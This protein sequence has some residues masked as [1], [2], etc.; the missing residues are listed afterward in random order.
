[1]RLPELQNYFKIKNAQIFPFNTSGGSVNRHFIVALRQK[2]FILRNIRTSVSLHR[3][4]QIHEMVLF[5]EKNELPLAPPILTVDGYHTIYFENEAWQLMPYLS[6]TPYSFKLNEMKKSAQLL[7]K[8]HTASLIN[9]IDKN[10]ISKKLIEIESELPELEKWSFSLALL[11]KKQ[12]S[13]LKQFNSVPLPFT[14]THG[15]FHGLNLLFEEGEINAVLDFDNVD[16]RPRL[17]DVAH[18]VLMFCR[19]GRGSYEIRPIWVQKFL[20]QYG[21]LLTHDEL[22]LLPAMMFLSKIPSK[23]LFVELASLG[24]DVTERVRYYLNVLESVVR[25]RNAIF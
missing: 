22:E 10:W 13:W 17:F 11:I 20:E 16:L 15:D 7:G 5:W 24:Y 3:L 18:A 12:L 4:D 25:Q 14:A 21:T 1:M 6:G 23:K 9:N 8:L 2:K 19:T